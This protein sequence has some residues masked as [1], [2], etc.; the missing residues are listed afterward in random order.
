MNSGKYVFAQLLALVNRY[1]FHKCVKRY[2]GDYRAKELNCWNQ[3]SQLFFGQL[4]SRNGL[5]DICFC[6][7]AH[8]DKL[9]H[10]G[11]QQSVNQ[12]TLSRANENRDW[13]IFADFGHYLIRLVQPLYADDSIPGLEIDNDVFLLD[14]TTISVSIVLMNWAKGKYSRGAVKMHTLLDLRGSIPTF[15]H[16]TDGKYHDINAFDELEIASGAIYVMDKAYIDFK[17]LGRI[18]KTEAFFVVRA[19]ENLKFKA[20]VSRKVDKTTGLRCDQ[21]IKLKGKKSQMHYPEKLRRIK[22]YDHE[23]DILLV[24]LTNNFELDP[25]EIVTIYKHRWKIEVFFRWIKQNLQIKTLWGHSINAV[26]I[27]LW[28]AICT[29]LIVA[30]LKYQTRSPY[31]VYELMQILGI[32]AF[33]KTPVNELVTIRKINRRLKEPPNLFNNSDL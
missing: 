22:Y 10:L 28:V 7:N 16:I 1:E 19:K 18:D 26:K 13:R 24:F 6:L 27:H 3:F 29:Y 4:T 33:D 30:Y 12:S 25:L 17:R 2:N 15:I 14:S 20:V 5:R 9:Y 32:S 8:K 11:I 23:K 31:S 21:S